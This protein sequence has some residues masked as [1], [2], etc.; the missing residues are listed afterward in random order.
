MSETAG[1]RERRK[2]REGEGEEREIPHNMK[3]HKRKM[4][5]ARVI[6]KS[7]N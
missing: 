5:N 4:L 2:K 3:G 6:R 7:K 1:E